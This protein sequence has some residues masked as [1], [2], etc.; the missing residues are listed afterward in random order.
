MDKEIRRSRRRNRE[1]HRRRRS[2]QPILDTEPE[3][4]QGTP[5][6]TSRH[7]MFT[8]PFPI[9]RLVLAKLI[10]SS[11]FNYCLMERTSITETAATTSATEENE[12]FAEEQIEPTMSS[13]SEYQLIDQHENICDPPIILCEELES[14]DMEC[15]LEERTPTSNG[16]L[17]V[18]QND[19]PTAVPVHEFIPFEKESVS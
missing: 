3:E 6:F 19:E 4:P 16:F 7:E 12:A 11:H 5:A 15:E 14:V 18:F 1:E 2:K 13:I 8:E 10:S 17:I 9:G